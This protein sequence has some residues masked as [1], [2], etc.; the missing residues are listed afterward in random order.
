MATGIALLLALVWYML[1]ANR[2]LYLL[3]N[4]TY[5]RAVQRLSGPLRDYKHKGD[6][7]TYKFHNGYGAIV[8]YYWDYTLTPLD[9]SRK[10]VY[11]DTISNLTWEECQELIIGIRSL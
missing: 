5:H 2:F 7:I 8:S 9:R 6:V 11:T 3:R 1:A 4:S 10:P